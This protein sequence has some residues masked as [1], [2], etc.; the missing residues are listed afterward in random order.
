MEN[1]GVLPAHAAPHPVSVT[2]AAALTGRNRLTCAFRPVLAIPHMI[3]VGGPIAFVL[4]LVWHPGKESGSEWSAGG[5]VLGAVAVVVAMIA[6][7]AIVF[8]GRYPTGLWKLAA[9]YLAW[10]VRAVAYLTMLRDEYPPFGDGEYPATLDLPFP[11]GDRD[12]VTVAFRLVLAI[13]HFLI[14]WLLGIAWAL[15]TIVVWFAIL[16]TGR[17]PPALY[18]FGTGVLRWNTR[19]EAYVLLLRDEYPPFS[20]A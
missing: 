7:F 11:H 5:G 9:F 17:M 4:S 10:R 13:P 12:R 18:E 1:I 2:V 19:L 3:L 20:L 14:V 15:G 6:W 16:L 8:T